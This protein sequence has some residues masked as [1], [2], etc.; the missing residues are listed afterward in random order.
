MA[1]SSAPQDEGTGSHA[2]PISETLGG[3]DFLGFG[4]HA[5]DTYQATFETDRGYA[6]YCRGFVDPGPEMARYA[7]W[8]NDRDPLASTDVLGFMEG[9]KEKTYAQVLADNPD[10]AVWCEVTVATC[11]ASW[12]MRRFVSWGRAVRAQ[13]PTPSAA[14]PPP[15]GRAVSVGAA[16]GPRPPPALP[17]SALVVGG[18]PTRAELSDE[19]LL[20]CYE[21]YT[22]RDDSGHYALGWPEIMSKLGMEKRIWLD[23][24]TRFREE[25]HRRRQEAAYGGVFTVEQLSALSRAEKGRRLHPSER[26]R[27]ATVQGALIAIGVRAPEGLAA[28]AQAERGPDPEGPAQLEG[29]FARQ[30]VLPCMGVHVWDP[31]PGVRLRQKSM[32]PPN[33]LHAPC[34]LEPRRGR[35]RSRSPP[36]RC[37]CDALVEQELGRT[38]AAEEGHVNGPK[39]FSLWELAKFRVLYN[40]EDGRGV[41]QHDRPSIMK[42]MGKGFHAYGELMRESGVSPRPRGARGSQCRGH[43][44]TCCPW[45]ATAAR[46]RVGGSGQCLLCDLDKLARALATPTG[47]SNLMRNLKQLANSHRFEYSKAWARGAIGD[48]PDEQRAALR[49]RCDD[50]DA[51]TELQHGEVGHRPRMDFAPSARSAREHRQLAGQR[52]SARGGS[53]CCDVALAATVEAY[54]K[55]RRDL[56]GRILFREGEEPGG[57]TSEQYGHTEKTW[58]AAAKSENR[59]RMEQLVAASPPTGMA[60]VDDASSYVNAVVQVLFAVVTRQP[61]LFFEDKL[62]WMGPDG[63]G[64]EGNLAHLLQRSSRARRNGEIIPDVFLAR[65]HRG[66][67]RDAREFMEAVM[68]DAST[69]PKLSAACCGKMRTRVMCETCDLVRCGSSSWYRGPGQVVMEKEFRML[70]LPRVSVARGAALPRKAAA[71]VEELVAPNPFELT[72]WQCPNTTTCV[73]DEHPTLKTD[74][75]WPEVLMVYV[76]NLDQI[77]QEAPYDF[78]GSATDR[79]YPLGWDHKTKFDHA[80]TGVVSYNA[81]QGAGGHYVA[82]VYI[83]G[84]WVLYDDA[85]RRFPDRSEVACFARSGTEDKPYIAVYQRKQPSDQIGRRTRTLP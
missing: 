55:L 67:E 18:D 33:L 81:S 31:A 9:Y 10:F 24:D 83:C 61:K 28:A 3:D 48:L 5:G 21:L 59:F 65:H 39:N 13:A 36:R 42:L 43:A 77:S 54:K 50:M 52:W 2:Q 34:C 26:P 79:A 72:D 45:S 56:A 47:T 38:R 73:H 53:T 44:G 37:P 75:E 30:A 6:E 84:T 14:S 32:Q 35:S 41:P 46:P 25:I 8:V 64:V 16:A 29:S 23:F 76:D 69:A 19:E 71:A 78:G 63:Y 15:P 85:T 20:R 11:G 68:L 51:R 70:R 17:S 22:L 4:Q 27:R 1:A 40:A 58:R 12:R 60:S 57:L 80:L 49:Q 7:R 74:V 62:R 66:I 82:F